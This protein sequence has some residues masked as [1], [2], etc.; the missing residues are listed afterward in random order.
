[1]PKRTKVQYKACT[2]CK[3]LVEPEIEV[4]PNCGSKTFS[5]EWEGMIIVIDPE[6]S[7]IAKIIGAS[8]AGKYAIKVR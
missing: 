8:K 2:K 6:K 3:F 1:M 4:C 7:A 5:T